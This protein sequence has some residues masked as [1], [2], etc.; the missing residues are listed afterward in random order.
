MPST[1]K[2]RRKGCKQ[3]RADSYA[4]VILTV[5][6]EECDEIREHKGFVRIEKGT[7]RVVADDGRDW[8]I[9]IPT[10]VLVDRIIANEAKGG[11]TDYLPARGYKWLGPPPETDEITIHA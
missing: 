3:K 8:G 7:W 5:L 9:E 10:T 1:E 4:M 11:W 2:Q 6:C